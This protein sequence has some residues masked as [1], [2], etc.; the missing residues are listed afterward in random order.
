MGLPYRSAHIAA[1]TRTLLAIGLAVASAAALPACGGPA[2]GAPPHEAGPTTVLTLTL[3]SATRPAALT[4][5]PGAA[6]VSLRLAGELGDVNQL[7]AEISP[8]GAPDQVKRWPVDGA[9]AG[10]DGAKA[11]VTLPTYALPAGTYQMTIWQGDAEIVQ[12][13]VFRV[14][15]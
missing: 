9:S 12:R 5:P 11:S 15:P 10:S 13:Y 4:I 2:P 14:L 6:Q 3:E 1:T 7:T 8:A